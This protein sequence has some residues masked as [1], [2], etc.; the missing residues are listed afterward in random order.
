MKEE[1]FI[2][3]EINDSIFLENARKEENVLMESF[4]I[5]NPK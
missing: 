4:I 3:A 1:R 2:G 5:P